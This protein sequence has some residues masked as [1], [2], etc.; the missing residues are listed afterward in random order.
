[1]VYQEEPVL[2]DETRRG[3]L[4]Y[5]PLQILSVTSSD[6]TQRYLEG[7]DFNVDACN[8][9]LSLT[10][11]SRIP[12][13]TL[14]GGE[15][16][17]YERFSD[18][19]GNPLFFAEGHVMHDF[20][21]SVHYSH[22]HQ[23][24]GK[25]QPEIMHGSFS[26]QKAQELLTTKR[27]LRITL[28]GDSISCGANA[29]AVTG[30]HPFR[31]PYYHILVETLQTNYAAD[32]H[33]R[34]LSRGGATSSYA[35]QALPTMLSIPA[36]IV[37]IAFGM[38]DATHNVAPSQFRDTIHAVIRRIQLQFPFCEIIL[39]ASLLPNPVWS[40]ANT[41][42][43]KEYLQQLHALSRNENQVVVADC[44]SLSAELYRRKRYPDYSG[45][46]INHP[47]DWMH[48]HYAKQI[49]GLFGCTCDW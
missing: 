36:D 6:G 39:I 22:E 16:P 47:N 49:G 18:G 33:L 15:G 14:I 44:H 10:E 8:G 48:L 5:S 11:Q 43:H 37:I 45:N 31:L 26:L 1:M 4:E 35:L 34:N 2:F 42:L 25:N 21:V 12:C 46:N 27:K 7:V 23:K 19:M 20:Q 29:S 30:V 24:Y 17:C 32:I 9:I 41:N 40:C 38:N 3:F 13:L 28:I